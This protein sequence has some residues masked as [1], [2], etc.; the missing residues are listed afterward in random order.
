MDIKAEHQARERATQRYW[1]ASLRL[2]REDPY[3][4]V[5]VDLL[6]TVAMFDS[7]DICRLASAAEHTLIAH[8]ARLSA[9]T[10]SAQ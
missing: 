5:A 10:A 7:P 1:T 2:L 6:R 4:K 9:P 8:A 3:C